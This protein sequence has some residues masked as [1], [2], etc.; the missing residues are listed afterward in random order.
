MKEDEIKQA[1]T[2]LRE[3][4]TGRGITLIEV[5]D[6]VTLGTSKEASAHIESLT[7][8]ELTRD[9]G[10]AG[11]ETLSIILYQG[12]P[13]EFTIRELAETVIALT[14]SKSELHFRPLPADDPKQRQPDLSNTTAALGPAGGCSSI[15]SAP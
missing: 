8:E 15:R 6:E 4:L 3:S 1:I 11:L 2:Q 13:G 7:K 12:N 5:E 9:L 14:G 10:K